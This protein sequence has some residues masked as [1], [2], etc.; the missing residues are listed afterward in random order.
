MFKGKEENIQIKKSE[1]SS[2]FPNPPAKRK[3]RISESAEHI[4]KT[5]LEGFKICGRNSHRIANPMER[6]HLEH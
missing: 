5:F 3:G 2:G 6:F 1:R 4:S